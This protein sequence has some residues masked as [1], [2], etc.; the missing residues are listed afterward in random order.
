MKT[1]ILSL[2]FAAT[3]G[4]AAGAQAA[5][6]IPPEN[7]SHFVGQTVMVC[8]KVEKTRYAQ[9]SE[10]SPTFL[11]MGGA[12]PRH[13]FSARIPNDLR[14]KFTPT[15]EQLEGRDVCVIGEVERDNSRAA[16]SVTSTSNIKL[17]QIK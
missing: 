12:Y 8:G 14:D 2:T 6:T 13:T 11:Y 3:L 16:I 7:A 17:A 15:P 1:T 10:G 5:E 9:N 4:L